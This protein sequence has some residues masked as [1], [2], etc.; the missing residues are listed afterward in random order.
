[1]QIGVCCCGESRRTE[2]SADVVGGRMLG[3]R[4]RAGGS[5]ES[6]GR[7]CTAAVM[8]SGEGGA[9]RLTA[10]RTAQGGGGELGGWSRFG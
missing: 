4:V 6:S 9:A 7:L 3:G 1:M 8:G 5:A 2:G 10:A